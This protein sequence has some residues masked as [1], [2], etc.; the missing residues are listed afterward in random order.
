MKNI[1]RMVGWGLVAF[2][3]VSVF[4]GVSPLFRAVIE[5]LI[6][7]GVAFVAGA[8]VLTSKELRSSVRKAIQVTREARRPSRLSAS[9][10]VAAGIDPLLPVRILKLAR[11]LGGTLTVAQVAIGLDVP[12]DHAQAGLDECV[13]AGNALPD[14]DIVRGHA[15]FRFPEFNQ[16]SGSR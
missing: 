6:A 1:R 8:W 7:G 16:E 11:D 3:A 9:R 15:L 2:G 13:R 12:L 5:P 4:V 10:S 14:W